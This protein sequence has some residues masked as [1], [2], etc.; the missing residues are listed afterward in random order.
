LIPY[1][2][3]R[4]RERERELSRTTI[5]SAVMVLTFERVAGMGRVTFVPPAEKGP[6]EVE[7][8]RG[9]GAVGREFGKEN[10]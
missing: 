4:E 3:E 9:D 10:L 1:E 2:R 5:G 8:P 7:E 6:K